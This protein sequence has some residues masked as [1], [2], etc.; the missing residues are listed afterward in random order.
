MT[1]QAT[2]LLRN[3]SNVSAP[4][5]I[6]NAKQTATQLYQ[7]VSDKVSDFLDDYMYEGESEWRPGIRSKVT[8]FTNW[9]TNAQQK[10][11]NWVWMVSTAGVVTILP[12]IYLMERNKSSSN[13]DVVKNTTLVSDIAQNTKDQIQSTKEQMKMQTPI[14]YQPSYYPPQMPYRYY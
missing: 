5:V 2:N 4:E 9:V 13:K 14:M 6:E 7:T 3:I 12:L 1:E 11:E 10:S 8:E